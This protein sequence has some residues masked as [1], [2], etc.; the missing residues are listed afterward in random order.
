[1]RFLAGLKEQYLIWTQC[2]PSP[3]PLYFLSFILLF[4]RGFIP[5]VS[6]FDYG[7][8]GLVTLRSFVF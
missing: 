2:Y 6:L 1:M 5:Y 3:F 8:Y 4:Y 7:G